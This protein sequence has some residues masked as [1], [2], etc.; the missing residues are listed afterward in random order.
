MRYVRGV[1]V[2]G[3][4]A[5]L[6][7]GKAAAAEGWPTFR[8]GPS[9]QGVAPYA[10]NL[11]RLGQPALEPVQYT[12][13]GLIWGTPVVDA[14]GNVYVGAAD[15]HFYALTPTGQLRWKYALQ[16]RGDAV[17]DSAA[18]LHPAGLVVVPGGDGALHALDPAT[19]ALRWR[20]D[21]YHSSAEAHQRGDVVNSFE[22]NVQIGPNGW[23]YAGSDNG[24]MYALNAEGQEQWH[25]CTEMMIWSSPAFAAD[26]SWMVFGSLDGWLYLLDP[27][28]GR[29]LD[30]HRIGSD[31]KSSPAV[32]GSEVYVGA[33][34]QRLHTFHVTPERRLRPRWS[35]ATDGE[36]YASPA[37]SGGQVVL[38]SLDGSVMALRDDGKLL[39]RYRTYSPVSA[40]PVITQDGLVYVG[41]ANGKL[42]ALDLNTGERRWSWASTPYPLKSNLDASVAVSPTG[43]LWV[44]SYAGQIYG[45]PFDHCLR[46]RTDT[47]CAFGGR[48]DL[49]EALALLPSGTAARLLVENPYR[50]LGVQP[51]QPLCGAEALRLKLVVR[52]GADY[53]PEAALDPDSVRLTSTPPLPLEH[54]VSS[55]GQYLV[56]RPQG[57]WPPNTRVQLALQGAYFPSRHWVSD[58]FQGH[59]GRFAQTLEVQTAPAETEQPSRSLQQQLQQ[60]PRQWAV[61][62][63]F[64]YYPAALETYT[65]AA[66][67]GQGYRLT[68][69]GVPGHADRAL[70]VGVP[71]LPGE[72][73]AVLPEPA[74][75]YTLEAQVRDNSLQALGRFEISAM[76]GT[77][78]FER[79]QMGL[80]ARPDG[81]LDNQFAAS[82][83][84]LGVRGNASS[85]QFPLSLV[86]RLCNARL[87]LHAGG[88]AFQTRALS[89]APAGRSL[90]G[91]KT[92]DAYA[93]VTL[94][95]PV[96]APQLTPALL[97]VVGWEPATGRL[98]QS[99]HAVLPAA[100][101]SLRVP[102]QATHPC[103][104]MAWQTLLNGVPLSASAAF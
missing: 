48:E 74:R 15:R 58:R 82:T 76:G 46:Q 96:L 39:W 57:F 53:V 78:P 34:D 21:A 84:C 19:G 65:P 26:G 54:T 42:Y 89:L 30:R 41:A 6:M 50:Q 23:L 70:L 87:Q 25:Y 16:A 7:G 47:R 13:S 1:Q 24:C 71:A 88:T 51:E 67:E 64:L 20:F 9:N 95:L 94:D 33:S 92:T 17:V 69:W 68:A 5:L 32:V 104:E 29:L 81:Q 27:R 60:G 85:Y 75:A 91:L 44:G 83:S 52:E 90:R 79:F 100:A 63:L 28:T 31:V 49:P 45:L 59:S 4:L 73:M 18:A 80:E 61:Q 37:V 77:I 72:D 103:A 8:N 38:A 3:L 99:G 2:A 22:G 14:Q 35:F 55:D 101:Q 93:E 40:S 86:H 43:Q 102:L 12:T 36:V 10:L 62:G 11:A 97:S 56:L 98:C 66:L